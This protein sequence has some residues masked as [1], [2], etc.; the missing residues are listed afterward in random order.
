MK[1]VAR[2]I[3]S[4]KRHPKLNLVALGDLHVGHRNVDYDTLERVIEYIKDT[5]NCLWL[6]MGDYADCVTFKDK[7]FDLNAVDP[8]CMTPD[9]QYR[10]VKQL[11]EPIKDKCLGLLDGNHDYLFWRRYQHNYVDWLAYELGVPY[12]TMDA[13]IRFSFVRKSGRTP[14]IRQV[15]I[16]AHHGWTGA[17]TVGGKINRIQDLA[18]IFPNL[19][20]YLMGHVHLLGQAPPQVQLSVDNNLNVVEHVERFVFTGGFLRGYMPDAVSYIETKTLTPASLGSPLIKI[21][22]GESDVVKIEITEL[23]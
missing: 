12:L 21:R 14:K 16:Y 6:G 9:L 3:E 13:Y 11:F 19:D 8:T 1:V 17:R 20:I 18:K 7:R 15:N 4:E 5:P 2:R 23:R 22:I 10:R